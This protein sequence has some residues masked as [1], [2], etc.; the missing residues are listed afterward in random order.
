M[1][2]VF[3]SSTELEINNPAYA[4]SDNNCTNDSTCPTWFTCNAGKRC[5]CDRGH[6]AAI[7]Y[8]DQA[9]FS[10]VLN[11]YCVTYDNESKSTYAG[12]CFYNC[13]MCSS[14]LHT[15]PKYPKTLINTSACTSF[16]RTGLLCG[17]CEEGHNPLIFSC[18]L[19]CVECP[20]G[21]KNW[22]KLILV[23]F[24]PLTAFYLFILIFNVN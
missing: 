13:L 23:G 12:P 14:S 22:W 5:Q 10:A 4:V 11:C 15:L 8:D 6:T 2:L 21:H 18:N 1:L 16:H 17:D 3:V 20:D 7:I 24:V 9:Q 19:S